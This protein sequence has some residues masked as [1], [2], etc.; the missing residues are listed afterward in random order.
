MTDDVG[1]IANGYHMLWG[2]LTHDD[3]ES[4]RALVGGLAATTPVPPEL[5]TALTQAVQSLEIDGRALP[6]F[7]R[8]APQA[9]GGT[10]VVLTPDFIAW[11]HTHELA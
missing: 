6:P 5:A 4:L 2:A 3:Q 9:P 1:A 8:S 10:G 11:V 7:V